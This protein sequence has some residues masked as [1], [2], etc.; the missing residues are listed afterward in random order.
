MEAIDEG[1]PVGVLTDLSRDLER[2]YDEFESRTNDYMD[3]L[4]EEVNGGKIVELQSDMDSIYKELYEVKSELTKTK[5]EI[6]DSKAKVKETMQQGLKVK[7]LDSPEFSGQIRDYPSFKRDYERHMIPSFGNDP[8]A[9]KKCLKGE[10]LATVKGVDD[11]FDEMFRRLDLKFGRPEKL[12]DAVLNELRQITFIKDGDNRGFISMVETVENCWLD[13]RKAGLESEMN[14]STM[15]SQIEKILPGVQKREWVI[16]KQGLKHTEYKDIFRIFLEFLLK[17]KCALEYMDSELRK[18]DNKCQKGKA[19]SAVA[20]TTSESCQDGIT[21]KLDKQQEVLQQVVKGLAQVA[22]VIGSSKVRNDTGANGPIRRGGAYRWRCWYHCVD[23]HEIGKC[24]VFAQLD[25]TEKLEL[26]RTNGACF[27]CLKQGH[28]SSRCIDRKPCEIEGCGRMHHPTL[29]SQN[30]TGDSLH[31][32]SQIVN[33]ENVKTLLMLNKIKSKGGELTTLWDPGANMSLIT[34][35]AARRLGL[36]GK[37]ITLSLTKVGN[38]SETIPTKEYVVPMYDDSGREWKILAFGIEEVTASVDYIDVG[39]VAN[40]FNG[41]SES[42]IRR[43]T[44]RVDLLIGTDCSVLLPEKVQ[45]VGGLQLMKSK[46]GY[47]IR[48]KHELLTNSAPNVCKF[49]QIHFTSGIVSDIKDKD[50]IVMG[51]ST[52]KSDLDKFFG[53]ENLGTECTPKCG[54]CKCG[55]CPPGGKD[56]TIQEERELALIQEGLKYDIDAKRWTVSYPWIR[57]PKELP[58][59]IGA[60]KARLESTERRLWRNGAEYGRLYDNQIKDMV[61]RNVAS[62]LSREDVMRYEGPVHYIPHHEVLKPESKTTPLRIVFNSSASFMRHVLNDYWAKGPNILNDLLSVLLRFRQDSVAVAGDI[63]KMYNAV[64]MAEPDQ[65]VHRFLWRDLNANREADHYVLK[66]VTFGDRPSGAIATM[67]L[68]KTAQMFENSNPDASSIIIE[69]SYVDDILF[70]TANMS[71][72]D[73]IAKEIDSILREGGFSVKHWTVSGTKK[74][75]Q[76]SV[77]LQEEKVLGMIWEPEMDVFRFRAKLNFS[78]RVRNVRE[79]EDLKCHEIPEKLP[80][81]LTHR[82]VLSQV[83]SIYDPLGLITPFVL[84]SKLLLRSLC[85][86][87]S[88][89]QDQNTAGEG[90]W[91]TPMDDQMREKWIN[92]FREFFEVET[93]EFPRCIKPE[94]AIGDP[95]LVVFSDGSKYAYGTCAYIRWETGDGHYVSRLIAAKNRIAPTRQLSIPRL[96]LCGAVLGARLR[97]KVTKALP[98]KFDRVFHLVDSMIVRAQIQKESYGFGTFTA[99]R[100][101]EIQT[102]TEKKEWWW[103]PG[104]HNP[105]DLTTRATDPRDLGSRSIW[106]GGPNFL[107]KSIEE[108]PINQ[109]CNV[110]SRDLPDVASGLTHNVKGDSTANRNC[111]FDDVDLSRYTDVNV[112][113][114]VSSILLKIA[115]SKSFRQNVNKMN[116]QDLLDAEHEWIEYVQQDMKSDWRTSFKRLGAEVNDKGI[117]VV[118]SRMAEWLKSTWNRSEFVLLPSGSNFAKLHMLTLHNKDHCGVDAALAKLRS[119]FWIPGARRILKAIR[120]RCV[121]CRKRQ[122][123]VHGQKMGTLP[124]ERLRPSPAFYYSAVDLFGPFTIRD[125]VKKRTHGKAYGVIFTCLT[126]RGVYLDLAD[127]YSTDSFMMVLRRF[128]TV[129]GYPR[130]LRSDVGTQLIAAS[131][132]IREMNRNWNWQ[133]IESFGVHSGMEWEFN[134]SADA[135]W[136]NGCCEALVKTAKSCLHA[137]IGDAVMSFSELQTVLFEVAS[138]MNERP[139][140]MKNGDPNEGSYLCPNDLLLGR[141]SNCVPPGSWTQKDCYKYRWKFIQQVVDT[142]WKRWMRDYFP[143]LIVRQ[144]WHTS[145]RNV[146]VGDV[147]LV[148]DSN[149]I[150]GQWRMAQV[151]DAKPGKDSKVRDVE[152]R[153]K[154][155][156]PGTAYHGQDDIK[157]RRSVHRI[158]VILPVEEH[159]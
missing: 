147:V 12:S 82:M 150:R 104:E 96:E 41:I 24:S 125:S 58:N 59:N 127:S 9:L 34:H 131:K 80:S 152:L 110:E 1:K 99:T 90:S 120:N 151:T 22:E 7:K 33:G 112:L 118:G 71:R 121:V 101:A 40:L 25:V 158:V 4:D 50:L 94:G 38:C 111:K 55:R 8:F 28:L 57:N 69:N 11:D 133:T 52:I 89:V 157:I 66:T 79:S 14:T 106:Q 146:R 123:I 105:A 21:D 128:V 44:G 67:A 51:R 140:G 43:P 139:I 77:N 93:I 92:F 45:E 153:Y 86:R 10:A 61:E 63:S 19:H 16:Y 108:W 56:F 30:R 107:R 70:S 155:Q 134:K 154:I 5:S 15:V 74:P 142:F 60:A 53:T 75:N 100:V 81:T 141:A 27:S 13:L 159:C 145:T 87:N 138:C 78:P 39:K 68:R 122:K 85:V 136:E 126:S 6:A 95:I 2:A 84:Q 36:C 130:K 26:L 32:A 37:D 72:A 113:L 31:G 98:Y 47:C 129:H 109:S 88:E 23:T 119:K 132:D 3:M 102:K 46:F 116:A 156:T 49:V 73:K 17:E 135:P 76:G 42:D 103:I 91:D 115:R 48:G 114:R 97:E 83:S 117:V 35:S 65:H 20:D 149:A 54:G 148:Q 143:S 29:H 18:E 62:K 64:R 144:K 137:A 124:L